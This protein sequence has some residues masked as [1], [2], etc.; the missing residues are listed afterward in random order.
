MLCI[1]AVGTGC[2]ING[3]LHIGAV[4]RH[5]EVNLDISGNAIHTVQH[6]KNCTNLFVLS[7][8]LIVNAVYF[9]L[10]PGFD[11]TFKR[12][13][14]KIKALGSSVPLQLG[15]N[16]LNGKHNPYLTVCLRA[17]NTKHLRGFGGNLLRKNLVTQKGINQSRFSRTVNTGKA[18]AYCIVV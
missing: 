15:I 16:S 7:H 5:R 17:G 9:M 13:L 6:G 11:F 10:N 4:Q 3:I 1:V 2:I 18:K 8:L 12:S 14:C